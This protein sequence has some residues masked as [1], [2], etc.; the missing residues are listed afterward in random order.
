MAKSRLIAPLLLR[1]GLIA[2]QAVPEVQSPAPGTVRVWF[3]RMSGL[4]QARIGHALQ[5]GLPSRGRDSSGPK[6]GAS[7]AQFS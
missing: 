4:T 7:S 2:L 5:V 6:K 3:L 1:L